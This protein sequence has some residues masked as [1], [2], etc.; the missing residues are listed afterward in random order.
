MRVSVNLSLIARTGNQIVLRK[1][2]Q[3]G[4]RVSQIEAAADFKDVCRIR[5]H[6]TAG[7]IFQNLTSDDLEEAEFDYERRS[8]GIYTGIRSDEWMWRPG[9]EIRKQVASTVERSICSVLAKAGIQVR[10]PELVPFWE[11]FEQ[12]KQTFV[13]R[14]LLDWLEAIIPWCWLRNRMPKP[15]FLQLADA[16]DAS[17]AA[18][19]RDRGSEREFW[20]AYVDGFDCIVVKGSVGQPGVTSR[21]S[22]GTEREAMEFLQTEVVSRR[23]EGWRT[24]QVSDFHAVT[25]S[26]DR[27]GLGDDHDSQEQVAL[28]RDLDS[29]LSE[30]GNGYCD[31]GDVL[32]DRITVFCNVLNVTAAKQLITRVITDGQLADRGIALAENVYGDEVAI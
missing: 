17:R 1:A 29:L 32:P 30:T 16:E 5:I 28:E 4:H 23:M 15:R 31:V 3:F 13:R 2:R 18:L 12:T 9:N 14:N 19:I 6:L 7:G 25:I 26:Y 20:N 11:A 10:H 21:Y 22:Y 27:S 8:G 24:V